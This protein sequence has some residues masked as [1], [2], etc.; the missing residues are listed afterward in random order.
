[1]NT[2]PLRQ[3]GIS[4]VELMIGLGLG[5]FVVAVGLVATTGHLNESR[6]LL[7]EARL[8]QD[9]R[10]VSDLMARTLR[11]AGHWQNAQA[12]LGTGEPNPNSDWQVTPGAIELTHDRAAGAS[13]SG[14]LAFRLREG[15]I[16]MRIGSGHWQALTDAGT[17]QITALE[18]TPQVRS[19]MMYGFC[20]RPCPVGTEATCPPRV[21]SRHVL[22]RIDARATHQPAVQRQLQTTVQLRNDRVLGAC[23][24]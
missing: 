21:E 14:H 18:L 5:L 17:S 19:L 12:A 9:V 11:R 4:L 3:A 8:M 15:V 13:E 16:D 23:P 2:R 6:Q 20:V 22:M 10:A 24:T 1:M 7:V